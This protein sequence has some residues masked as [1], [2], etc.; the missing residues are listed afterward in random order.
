MGCRSSKRAGAA[1]VEP[2]L[3]N[4]TIKC[5]VVKAS[6]DHTGTITWKMTIEVQVPADQDMVI[7]GAASNKIMIPKDSKENQLKLADGGEEEEEVQE[8][9]EEEQ[10]QV[11]DSP[12]QIVSEKVSTPA[13]RPPGL[14]FLVAIQSQSYRTSLKCTQ[15]KDKSS[16]QSS[17]VKPP[18]HQQQ[19]TRNAAFSQAIRAR[20]RSISGDE[21]SA[22][23][24][25]LTNYADNVDKNEEE[26]EEEPQY[27]Q[28]PTTTASHTTFTTTPKTPSTLP[29]SLLRDILVKKVSLRSISSKPADHTTPE[30]TGVNSKRN[31]F[32]FKDELQSRLHQRRR[33]VDN[34]VLSRAVAHLAEETKE[35]RM[36]ARRSSA[37][38]RDMP[39]DMF[40]AML[41]KV[42]ELLPAHEDDGEEEGADSDSDW[43]AQ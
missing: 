9:K 13:P 12:P 17:P 31:G 39:C 24:L 41:A 15:T 11:V 20:S 23:R 16:F 28:A 29:P 36:A 42:N 19:P 34:G 18:H 4:P 5:G 40:S 10:Q 27:Q 37:P 22:A 25:K 1:V 8:S 38:P 3:T 26:E 33:T 21:L 35:S 7:V 43:D 2:H 30:P 6:T 14:P 32:T